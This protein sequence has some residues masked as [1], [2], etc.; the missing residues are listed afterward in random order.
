M[1]S[2]AR[3][4]KTMDALAGDL[5]PVC[6]RCDNVYPPGATVC[7]CGGP[8]TLTRI[9]AA[10]SRPRVHGCECEGLGVCIACVFAE[11]EGEVAA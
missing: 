9:P 5:F 8:L 3:D 10:P 6:P 1:T 4:Q 11:Y 2:Q 7:E